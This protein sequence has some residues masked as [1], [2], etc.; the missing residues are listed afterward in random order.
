M[1]EATALPTEPLL[2]KD[3]FLASLGGHFKRYFGLPVNL[4]L[5][6][7]PRIGDWPK[8][9]LTEYIKQNS[10]RIDLRDAFIYKY[11]TYC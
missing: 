8:S 11:K 7:G 9:I 4:I 2:K 10:L 1:S 3:V 6:V 5:F